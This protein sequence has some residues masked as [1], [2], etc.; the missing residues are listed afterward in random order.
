MELPRARHRS[1]LSDSAQARSTTS[2]GRSCP[3]PTPLCRSGWAHP[4]C[5][6]CRPVRPPEQI[7]LKS[8]SYSWPHRVQRSTK[9]LP[10]SSERARRGMPDFLWRPSTFCEMTCLSLPASQSL[11]T[12]P[13]VRPG[14]ARA[15]CS[16]M[17]PRG[18]PGGGAASFGRSQS[19]GPVGSTVFVPLRKSATPAP[20]EMPA[21]VKAMA[22]RADAIISARRAHFSS[23]TAGSSKNSVRR[24]PSYAAQQA[25]Q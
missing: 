7:T 2:S 5:S 24:S 13:C 3:K 16:R 23:R 20:V 25:L 18:A 10:W 14:R 17:P 8:R 19:P 6:Q 9:M 12:T 11:C 4:R 21:P 15:H 1:A 22:Y